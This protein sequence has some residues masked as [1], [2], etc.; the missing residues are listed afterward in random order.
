MSFT[1]RALWNSQCID[2]LGGFITLVLSKTNK[3]ASLN[4]IIG[5]PFYLPTYLPT[6]LFGS[7]QLQH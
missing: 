7:R 3:I 1:L 2:S 4:C 5:D 6:Y